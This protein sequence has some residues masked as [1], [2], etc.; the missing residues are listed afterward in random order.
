MIRRRAVIQGRVQGVGFRYSASGQANT[1][2]ISGFA[3]NRGDG[4]VEV[5]IEGEE[6]SVERMLAWLESGPHGA[7]VRSVTVS[8]CALQ[9]GTDFQ[10]S[11]EID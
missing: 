10:I 6:T 7:E 9:G 8:D 11:H 2:G 1:L 4:S 3:R 5:E